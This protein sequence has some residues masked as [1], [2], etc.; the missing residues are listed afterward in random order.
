MDSSQS[1]WIVLACSLTCWAGL[2]VLILRWMHL[3]S[4]SSEKQQQRALESVDRALALAASSDALTYQAIRLPEQVSLYSDPNYDPSDQGE[5]ERINQR[6]GVV[7]LED[8]EPL[9]DTTAAA[10]DDF[11]GGS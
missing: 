9:D 11:F 4:K 1:L 2:T 7:D 6:R 5:I 8:E 3:I 10:L